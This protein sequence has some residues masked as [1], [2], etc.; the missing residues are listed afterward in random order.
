[1]TAESATE[2][3]KILKLQTEE[4]RLD[5]YTYTRLDDRVRPFQ[6]AC[7]IA[8]AAAAGVPNNPRFPR[9]RAGGLPTPHLRYI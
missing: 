9:P 5:D 7:P 2:A 4:Y 3:L 1:M 8:V 6:H